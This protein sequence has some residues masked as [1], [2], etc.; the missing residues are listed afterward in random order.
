MASDAQIKANAKYDAKATK[1]FMMKLNL[2]N[3]ADII[4]KLESVENRQGYLKDLIRADI[5][6]K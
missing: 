3:D 5:A 1:Q 4:K 2:K 6:G